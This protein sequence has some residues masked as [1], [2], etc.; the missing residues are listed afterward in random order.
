[1]KTQSLIIILLILL[2]INCTVYKPFS[3]NKNRKESTR[4]IKDTFN[5]TSEEFKQINEDSILFEISESLAKQVSFKTTNRRI[6]SFLSG[7]YEKKQLLI[8]L[9]IDQLKLKGEFDFDY[10]DKFNGRRLYFNTV[11]EYEEFM[12]KLDCSFIK[13]VNFKV[14]TLKN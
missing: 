1:M 8:A 3:S 7:N 13:K 12:K 14:D 10:T 2:M 5:L 4:Q 9:N 11:K 6:D